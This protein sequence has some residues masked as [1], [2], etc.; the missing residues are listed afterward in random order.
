MAYFGRYRHFKAP[1]ISQEYLPS[2]L[3]NTLDET[4]RLSNMECILRDAK[5]MSRLPSCQEKDWKRPLPLGPALSM[6]KLRN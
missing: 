2:M 4:S 3:R 6:L 1:A 5:A